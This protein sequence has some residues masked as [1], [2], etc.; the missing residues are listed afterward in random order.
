MKI[1]TESSLFAASSALSR[2]SGKLFSDETLLILHFELFKV[3]VLILLD[4][5]LWYETPDF[6]QD[7]NWG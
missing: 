7:E 6:S 1:P 4:G 3:F 2:I 5:K